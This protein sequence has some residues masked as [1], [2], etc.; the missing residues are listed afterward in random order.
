MFLFVPLG[1][2]QLLDL[3]SPFYLLSPVAASPQSPCAHGCTS[4]SCISGLQ[5]RF[6]SILS[7]V[8]VSFHE[9]ALADEEAEYSSWDSDDE[10]QKFIQNMNPPRYTNHF[11]NNFLVSEKNNSFLNLYRCSGSPLTTPHVQVLQLFM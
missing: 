1:E 11:F 8:F 10:Y 6:D 3:G 4:F 7:E 5:L 9:A 2:I